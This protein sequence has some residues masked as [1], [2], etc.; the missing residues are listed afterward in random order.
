MHHIALWRAGLRATHTARLRTD[1]HAYVARRFLA[2][3][4]DPPKEPKKDEEQQGA[5]S[6]GAGEP[7]ERSFTT[8]TSE[9][10]AAM[11]KQPLP[12]LS[13]PLGVPGRPTSEKVSWSERHPE[14]YDR[15]ARIAKRRMIVKEATRGYFHDF[16]E[17]RSHGGK[18]WRSP[19]TMIRHDVCRLRSPRN[20][21]SFPIS[22]APALRTARRSTRPT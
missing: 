1:T 7:V 17:I 19:N 14:W 12:Y 16:H 9:A 4:P 18:T 15:D 10:A 8:S 20:R 5:P 3:R 21:S 13:R 6:P 2:D 11:D 22:K